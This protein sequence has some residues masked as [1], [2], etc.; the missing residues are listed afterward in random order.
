MLRLF[1]LLRDAAVT[2]R[3]VR[4]YE[5]QGLLMP[6][7]RDQYGRRIYVPSDLMRLKLIRALRMA[8]LSI[9][10][11]R[12]VL[13]S[14]TVRPEDAT[15]LSWLERVEASLAHHA[16]ELHAQ[17][18]AMQKGEEEVMRAVRWL[19]EHRGQVMSAVEASAEDSEVPFIIRALWCQPSTLTT[20]PP[21]RGQ[22]R[23]SQEGIEYVPAVW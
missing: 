10:A 9:A 17:L 21:R 18:Q 3:A 14:R 4:F 16:R 20:L 23:P 1:E 19:Q 5:E 11:I 2:R 13:D 8:G 6:A 15:P 22:D 7:G 12:D